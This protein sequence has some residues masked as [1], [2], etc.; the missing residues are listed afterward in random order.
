MRAS[1]RNQH[2]NDGNRKNKKRKQPKKENK[3]VTPTPD[4]EK[5]K[6]IIQNLPKSNLMSEMRHKAKGFSDKV[7]KAITDPTRKHIRKESV[8]K[9]VWFKLFKTKYSAKHFDVNR[10]YYWQRSTIRQYS[11]SEDEG[12]IKF[13]AGDVP[14]PPLKSVL[15]GPAQAKITEFTTTISRETVDLTETNRAPSEKHVIPKDAETEEESH[16]STEIED[17]AEQV[18]TITKQKKSRSKKN[19]KKDSKVSFDSSPHIHVIAPLEQDDIDT[20]ASD[21]TSKYQS[22][23]EESKQVPPKYIRYRLGMQLDKVDEAIILDED[24]EEEENELTPAQRVR[25]IFMDLVK[26]IHTSIDQNAMIISWKN[27][28]G[29]STMQVK[30]GKDFPK[31]LAQIAVFFDGYRANMKSKNRLYF[32]FCLNTPYQTEERTSKK[33]EEWR[34]ANGYILYKCTIQAESARIIGWLVYTLGF[35]NIE[36]IK[37]VLQEKTSYQWGLVSNV[38]TT[39]DKD[40]SWRERMKAYHV[41]VQSD[42]AEVAKDLVT[43]LFSQ[44][45]EFQKYKSITDCYMFVG[46]EKQCKGEKLATIY[47]AMVGRHKFREMHCE[48]VLVQFIVK[49]IDTYITTKDNEEV[50]LRQMIL[51]LESKD[52]KYGE[53]KLFHSIDFTDNAGNVWFKNKTGEKDAKG[54]YLSYYSWDEAE[55]LHVKEGLGLYLGQKF[56]KSGVYDYLSED[57]WN[58]LDAW[59][60]NKFEERWETP[61]ERAMAENVINDPTAQ[62][63]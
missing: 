17:E 60:Y 7:Q 31:E 28:D 53:Q 9:D 54:Y 59:K 13:P 41:M 50:T 40:I 18:K 23:E 15:K 14:L 19:K 55:A 6:Q 21:E 12:E 47:T 46:N 49:D 44:K 36:A 62:I 37:K 34:Q 29:F 16:K 48:I 61:E 8:Y 57:H 24:E 39:A 52:T 10:E 1:R 11:D 35:T 2:S 38:I 20:I 25:R 27:S 22:K 56:G 45:P 42:K 51:D 30:I 43:V 26:F 32:K 33:L 63:M 3:L 5:V 58:K 4:K